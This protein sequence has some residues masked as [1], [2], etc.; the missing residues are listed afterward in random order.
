MAY[1]E[2]PMNIIL[3]NRYYPKGFREIDSWEYYHYKKS[4][5]LQQTQGRDLMLS[6]MADLNK[7]VILRKGQSTRFIRLN[8]SNYDNIIHGRVITVYNTMK[9]DEDI[10][11]IDIDI[12]DFKKGQVAARETYEF[13]MEK[14]PII[15]RAQIRFTG[16]TSFHIFCNL[17]RKINVDSIRMLFRKFLSESPLS[18]K[19]TI[20]H[21]RIRGVPN[22]DLSPNKF[23]GAHIA[24]HS[25]SVLGLKCM[26]VD[27]GELM[28]FNPFKAKIPLAKTR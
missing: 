17:T 3:K 26:E 11:I 16:K 14:V 27:H 5:I 28:S 8:N 23:R 19:Y 4:R 2:N 1:P 7:P 20:E 24:L 22:L 15:R 21:K 18:K 9:R 12:D 13:V 25:L 6:V 10:A